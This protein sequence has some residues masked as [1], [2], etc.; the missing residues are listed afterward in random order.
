LKSLGYTLVLE[1]MTKDLVEILGEEI[2]GEGQGEIRETEDQEEILV[3][4]V[5]EVNREA[6]V[7]MEVEGQVHMVEGPKEE[8]VIEEILVEIQEVMVEISQEVEAE[9]PV[10][11]H[12]EKDQVD[13]VRT[14]E[15]RIIK[16][17]IQEIRVGVHM[18]EGQVQIKIRIGEDQVLEGLQIEEEMILEIV[19]DREEDKFS[20][21]DYFHNYREHILQCKTFL[22]RLDLNGLNHLHF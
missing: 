1:G 21:R 16:D 7:P 13:Q 6:V 18:V 20:I 12:M 9:I 11:V 22:S 17:Q 2:L 3:E 4:E 15:V 14:A 10:E 19:E 8:G 5:G